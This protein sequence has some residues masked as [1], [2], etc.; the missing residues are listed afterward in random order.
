MW[1][2]FIFDYISVYQYVVVELCRPSVST[3]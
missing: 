3:F 1:L 2:T